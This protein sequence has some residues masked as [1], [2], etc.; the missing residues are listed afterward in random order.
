MVKHLRTC[1]AVANEVTTRNY[2]AMTGALWY[3]KFISF[4]R[5]YEY[6]TATNKQT[7]LKPVCPQGY[8]T[9]FHALLS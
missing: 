4:N 1:D 3:V 2:I 6:Y 5:V 7:S 9:F 8:I